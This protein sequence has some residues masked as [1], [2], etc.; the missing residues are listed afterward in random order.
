MQHNH[1]FKADD[2]MYCSEYFETKSQE[3]SDEIIIPT[4][5][6]NELMEQFQ[7]QDVLFVTLYNTQTHKSYMVTLGSA[8]NGDPSFIFIPQWILTILEYT[9][10]LI[11]VDIMNHLKQLN[12]PIATKIT[13]TPHD[14]YAFDIDIRQCVERTIMNLH[15]IQQDSVLPITHVDIE[16]MI[17]IQSVEPAPMSRI[18]V[19]EVEVEFINM[20][21]T[22]PQIPS[23]LEIPVESIVHDPSAPSV[24]RASSLPNIHTWD[25][26][27]GEDLQR[28]IREA[29]MKRF[30]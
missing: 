14:I 7:D 22:P 8:H 23:P 16:L 12:I 18:V 1:M 5:Y 20:F 28:I 24:P 9:D 27:E 30:Q 13:I 10:G 6:F 21:N 2:I 29:R 19:G 4:Y 25:S 11:R 17:Y 15:S 26:Q 3:L